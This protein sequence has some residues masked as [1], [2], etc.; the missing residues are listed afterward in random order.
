MHHAGLLTACKVKWS[1]DGERFFVLEID[2]YSRIQLPATKQHKYVGTLQC[3][4]LWLC[5]VSE[6]SHLFLPHISQPECNHDSQ[7][8][9][10]AT[11]PREREISLD[12]HA[13]QLHYL[14]SLRRN[15]YKKKIMKVNHN[16]TW[17]SL[18]C[19]SCFVLMVFFLIFFHCS[20][21][22]V[23]TALYCYLCFRF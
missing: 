6:S 1:E 9:E 16:C 5:A 3:S 18:E 15:V 4:T 13:V 14:I 17:L 7:A 19:M 12:S 22:W 21:L 20:S 2:L 23:N 10:D 8:R 11:L